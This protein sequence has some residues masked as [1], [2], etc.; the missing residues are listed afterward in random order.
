M[1][2]LLLPYIYGMSAAA[3]K[4][5]ARQKISLKMHNKRRLEGEISYS[6]LGMADTHTLLFLT[7]PFPPPTQLLQVG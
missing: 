3:N 1:P 2:F 4:H 7:P 5:F 6:P